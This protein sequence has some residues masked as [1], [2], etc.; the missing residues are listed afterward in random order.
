MK[1]L[2]MF[3]AFFIILLLSNTAVSANNGHGGL[4]ESKLFSAQLLDDN[5]VEYVYTGTVR[6]F[7]TRDHLQIKI[8]PVNEFEE[9]EIKKVYLY[10]GAGPVPA[11]PDDGFPLLDQFTYRVIYDEPIREYRLVLPFGTAMEFQWG[12]PYEALRS[13]NIS[14]HVQMVQRD[15]NGSELSHKDLWT[16][17]PQ[18]EN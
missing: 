11:D 9:W 12:E 16:F 17:N 3:C 6:V 4:V 18:Y 14:A 1:T 8:A 13:Q 2:Q 7:N 15:E 5:R 10:V